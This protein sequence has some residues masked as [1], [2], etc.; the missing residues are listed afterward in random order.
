MIYRPVTTSTTNLAQTIYVTAV[1]ICPL[2][3][4]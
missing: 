4:S 1:L 3:R 2:P